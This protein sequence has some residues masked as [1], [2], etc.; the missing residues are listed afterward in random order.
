MV[1]PNVVPQNSDI[2]Q[3]NFAKLITWK[4][5]WGPWVDKDLVSTGQDENTNAI[6][7]LFAVWL[8]LVC[9]ISKRNRYST[10]L[11][12]LKRHSVLHHDENDGWRREDRQIS[13]RAL[14]D[15]EHRLSN[16]IIVRHNYFRDRRPSLQVL[17]RGAAVQSGHSG[18][19]HCLHGADCT[20]RALTQ[21]TASERSDHVVCRLSRDHV[22]S[23]AVL[24]G[25]VSCRAFCVMFNSIMVFGSGNKFRIRR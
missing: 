8:L 3:N 11:K 21:F 5:Y 20:A 12:K 15:R 25:R 24:L 7:L 23:C 16:E 2:N 9:R 17:R 19:A 10:V 22:N 1:C 14:R 13:S 4:G 6:H 18:G